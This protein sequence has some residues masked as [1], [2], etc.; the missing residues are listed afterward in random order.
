WGRLTF[1]VT[2][3]PKSAKKPRW[4]SLEIGLLTIVSLLFIVILA[5]IVLFATKRTDSG[6]WRVEKL[7]EQSLCLSVKQ[8]MN[9][10]VS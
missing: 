1:I 3:P 8:A 10:L 7:I 6:E 9:L 2:V 5:L 4:T